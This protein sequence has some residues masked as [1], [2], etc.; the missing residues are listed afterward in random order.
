MAKRNP[1]KKLASYSPKQVVAD[2]RT[3]AE[4]LLEL[5]NLEVQLTSARGLNNTFAK[6]GNRLRQ[7]RRE[8]RLKTLELQK[9][10]K[11][12]E[13]PLLRDPFEKMVGELVE[14]MPELSMPIK[15]ISLDRS[16]RATLQMVMER[17][18]EFPTQERAL[19]A[20]IAMDRR[21]RDYLDDYMEINL[22]GDNSL[23]PIR[24]NQDEIVVGGGVHAA[25]Y[26]AVRVAMGYPKPIVIERGRVGGAFAASRNPSF[27]LNS[28]NRPGNL[29]LPGELGALNVLPG[30][31]LQPSDISGDEYQTNDV[32]GF[33]ARLSLAMNSQVVVRDE[34]GELEGQSRVDLASGKAFIAGRVIV[35][36]GLGIAQRLRT[37]EHER[38][39]SF[40]EFMR[41]MDSP[42][43][44]RGM[45]KV[46]VV[47]A[48]DSGKT[49]IESLTGQGPSVM[50]AVSLDFPEE[51]DWYGCKEDRLSKERWEICSRA[52]YKGIGS[53]LPRADGGLFRVDPK[54][55]KAGSVAV[56]FNCVY[57]NGTPYDY[58]INCVGFF[59]GPT[60]ALNTDLSICVQNG[61]TIG[62]QGVGSRFY[63]VG[64]AA[65]LPVG[66][67]EEVILR[68]IAENKT[69]LFRYA[70]R[71]AGLAA[72]LPKV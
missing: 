58:V 11:A 68:G 45:K 20:G 23:P 33:L 34:V 24:A 71:T 6:E 56:G 22:F 10:V 39:F 14:R 32:L 70:A 67:E 51:I 15:D 42:F 1:K 18:R 62:K 21:A 61:L 2:R 43:P 59:E 72:A 63:V 4:L 49:A 50:S 19:L 57:V 30:A 27:F 37:S 46:A 12:L 41:R 53:L 31:P 38:I 69:S 25:I 26:C 55:E 5:G 54:T 48:G 44:M 66:D 17:E 65:N 40:D 29:S 60:P 9:R 13:K 3:K 47:G 52:R 35:A 28:R 64:P 7:D 16:M 36:T 8:L